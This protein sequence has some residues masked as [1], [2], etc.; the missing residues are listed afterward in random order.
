M[1]LVVSNLFWIS[2]FILFYT[3][4]GYAM[5]LWLIVQLKRV[6][7][8]NQINSGEKPILPAV[9]II[10]AAY[11]EQDVIEQKIKNTIQ[12][13][14]P[15]NLLELVFIT[16]GSSDQTVEII[17]RYPQIK[18]LHEETRNGKIAALNRAIDFIES[19]FV[20]FTDANTILNKDCIEKLTSHY[21]NKHVGGVAGEK[22][23]LQR[24]TGP[25]DGGE[26][27]YWKYESLLKKLD[28]ELY[29]VVGA[30]GELFS[31]RTRLYEKLPEDTL[32]E[33]FVQSLKLCI[34]GFVVRYE[35]A[36]YSL[37]YASKSVNDEMKRKIRISA[38]AFQ[39]LSLLKPLFNFFRYPIVFFQFISHRILRWTVCPL[40]LPVFFVSNILL[41]EEGIFFRILL[42][43]QLLFYLSACAGWYF[44]SRNKRV[45]GI[46]IP[47]Y[48]LFINF[49]VFLGFARYL[50][51][52]QSVLWERASR[53]IITD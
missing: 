50:R 40:A 48:F 32:I 7:Y 33:D 51:R 36:A 52:K 44:A 35:P 38:G 42:I 18:L 29:T 31:M 45:I 16:D 5:V 21:G 11:N 14:Y 47:F 1:V 8:K 28:A 9:A 10:V 2:F 12:L 39:A 20:V 26:G 13:S 4:A 27:L 17:Q 37:E 23:I 30:A 24:T 41:Y 19:P 6:I 25:V 43:I 15:G 22:K 46:D 53:N 49:S 34:K 3:Y